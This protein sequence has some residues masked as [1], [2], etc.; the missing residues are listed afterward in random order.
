[1]WDVTSINEILEW[2]LHPSESAV[3]LTRR[4]YYQYFGQFPM[5]LYSSNQKIFC[6]S[7]TQNALHPHT[8]CYQF[9]IR[10]VVGKSYLQIGFAHPGT[11]LIDPAGKSSFFPV[12]KQL[13]PPQAALV[14]VHPC[15]SWGAWC[16]Y[17]DESV[18]CKEWCHICGGIDMVADCKFGYRQVVYPVVLG[19]GYVRMQ[20]IFH[21]PVCTFSLTICFRVMIWRE[22]YIDTVPFTQLFLY[23]SHHL[24][25]LVIDHG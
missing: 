13:Y 1:M 17:V 7:Q 9:C 21:Y 11:K 8:P 18:I 2:G 23:H 24:P 5:A 10:D 4:P 15:I 19:I 20:L 6:L 12:Y 14:A 25:L 16:W 3:F 22:F